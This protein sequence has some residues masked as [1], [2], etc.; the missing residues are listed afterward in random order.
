MTVAECIKI[1]RKKAGMTQE[2]LGRKLGVSGSMIAQYETGKRHPKMET[3]EDI[4]FALGMPYKQV[5]PSSTMPDGLES[6]AGDVLLFGKYSPMYNLYDDGNEDDNAL[7]E[8]VRQ[9]KRILEA[10]EIMNSDGQQKAVE[11]VEEL[12]EIP[13]YQKEP[14]QPPQAPSPPDSETI[15]EDDKKSQRAAESH[16]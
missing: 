10:F 15:P 3:K 9:V 13:R 8:S 5:F 6:M 11:R 7:K 16:L 4:A 2:E 14:Q 12:T 1:A